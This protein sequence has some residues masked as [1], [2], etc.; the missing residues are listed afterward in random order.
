MAK[1]KRSNERK[2]K[3]DFELTETELDKALKVLANPNSSEAEKSEAR[4]IVDRHDKREIGGKK[5]QNEA[6]EWTE[7]KPKNW[8]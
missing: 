8:F 7:L 5:E 1:E 3:L 6:S 2:F 4:V